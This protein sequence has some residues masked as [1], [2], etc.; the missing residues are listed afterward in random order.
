MD[1]SSRS[2]APLLAAPVT[3]AGGPHRIALPLSRVLD[4]ARNE[5]QFHPSRR[6]A[7][8]LRPL[9]ALALSTAGLCKSA[10]AAVPA[11]ADRRQQS[12]PGPPAPPPSAAAGERRLPRST[13][14]DARAGDPEVLFTAL[15]SLVEVVKSLTPGAGRVYAHLGHQAVAAG[16]EGP[17]ASFAARS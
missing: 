3:A 2:N 16:E 17:V 15:S 14:G 5:P 10:A 12:A 8:A 13:G 9:L 1:S 7:F 4:F 11:G 6:V